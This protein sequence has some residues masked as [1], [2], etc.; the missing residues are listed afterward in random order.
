VAY[1]PSQIHT[2]E[3]GRERLGARQSLNSG[4]A[5][6]PVPAHEDEKAWR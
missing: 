4:R 6:W 5:A 1:S 3:I 2:L